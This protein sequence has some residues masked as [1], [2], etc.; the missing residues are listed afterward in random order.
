LL[1]INLTVPGE[2]KVLRGLDTFGISDSNPRSQAFVVRSLDCKS[3]K[4]LLAMTLGQVW[5]YEISSRE[6]KVHEN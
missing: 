2:F 1:T 4:I 5:Q 3:H 6:E